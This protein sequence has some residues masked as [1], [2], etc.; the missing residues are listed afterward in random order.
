MA[1]S[2]KNKKKYETIEKYLYPS[3]LFGL[4]VTGFNFIFLLI[5]LYSSECLGLYFEFCDNVIITAIVNT[6]VDVIVFGGLFFVDC[7]CL[8]EGIIFANKKR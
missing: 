8:F 4:M 3:I 7:Y 2:K 1:R 6:L 5:S